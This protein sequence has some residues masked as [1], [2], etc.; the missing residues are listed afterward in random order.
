[1]HTGNH[2]RVTRL[3]GHRREV[4]VNLSEHRRVR[5]AIGA[6]VLSSLWYVPWLIMHADYAHPL[7]SVPFVAAFLYLIVQVYISAF[8]N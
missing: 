5:L 7:L 2:A 8:N 1:M 6:I 4:D 3:P